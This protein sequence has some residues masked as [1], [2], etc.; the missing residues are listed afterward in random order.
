M[1]Q[2]KKLSQLIQKLNKFFKKTL[3]NNLVK[4]FLIR[5]AILNNFRSSELGLKTFQTNLGPGKKTFQVHVA[6]VVAVVAIVVVN[7]AVVVVV[8]ADVA[9]VA[10]VVV[11]VVVA[12]VVVV[13]ADVGGVVVVVVRHNNLN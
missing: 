9:V 5:A 4:R 10:V 2:C 13:V 11:V 6:V 3:V 12:V 1:N 7:V 8:V